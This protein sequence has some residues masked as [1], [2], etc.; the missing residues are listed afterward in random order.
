MTNNEKYIKAFVEAFDVAEADV[1]NL[2]SI[3]KRQ[4]RSHE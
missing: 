3:G 1:P 2:K 4:V